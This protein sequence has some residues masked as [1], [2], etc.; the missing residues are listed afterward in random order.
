[1]PNQWAGCPNDYWEGSAGLRRG[2]G[3]I[4]TM[5]FGHEGRM[6]RLTACFANPRE[7]NSRHLLLGFCAI[8][9]NGKDCSHMALFGRGQG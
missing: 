7:D 4:R 6:E 3:S 5:G 2:G 1:V 8:L 9:C